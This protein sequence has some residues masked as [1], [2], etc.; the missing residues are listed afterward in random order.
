[1]KTILIVSDTPKMI[2][3]T[4]CIA[5]ALIGNSPLDQ[6]RAAD[7]IARIQRLINECDR[8][9]PL[10]PDGKHGDRHTPTCGCEDQQL[11]TSEDVYLAAARAY[12]LTRFDY[13]PS[14]Y[15]N[16]TEGALQHLERDAEGTATDEW[17]RAVVDAVLQY[18]RENS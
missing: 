9:R 8:H 5:A 14:V 3:E 2:R 13:S 16:G 10:G 12:C 11:T 1:M 17:L 7:D 6:Q 18:Q 15:Y 4:L